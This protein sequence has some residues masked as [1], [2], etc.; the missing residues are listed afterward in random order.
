MQDDN[1]RLITGRAN[2]ALAEAIA[3]VLG[4]P[5]TGISSTRFSDDEI[6]VEI[7]DNVRGEDVF[8][9]QPTNKPAN[10]HLMELL[11]IVDALRRGSARRITAVIPYYGYGRQDRKTGS[12]T[13]ITAKLIANMLQSAG[14]NRVI[15]VD[16]HVPQI[17]AFFEIPADHLYAR[18]TFLKD[19]RERSSN[20]ENLVIVSP[21]VGGVAR[22]RAYAQRLGCGLAIIDKRRDRPNASEVMHV[23]GEVEGRDCILVDD[24]V[25][26]AGT[27]CN[28]AAALQ[29]RGA[30]RVK[31]YIT[32]GVL[33]GP[34]RDRLEASC[35]E[36][37]VITDTIAQPAGLGR[38]RAVSLAPLLAKAILGVAREESVSVLFEED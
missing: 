15:M 36:E 34:A 31:A 3:G 11:V 2:P 32:H 29:A 33:S 1:I 37:L 21:D 10:D 6:F 17:Q 16:L 19:M 12:R 38:V 24:I 9:V 28:G 4:L 13:P 18:P 27:L 7:E 20:L 8:V 30:A 14:I 26:T 22:A 5:L 35:L 23:I 25:D